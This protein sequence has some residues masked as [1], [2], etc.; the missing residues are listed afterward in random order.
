MESVILAQAIISIVSDFTFALY[1]ILILWNVKIKTKDKIGLC[2]LMGLG[3]IT[4][5]CCIVRTVLNNQALAADSSYGGITN[6]MWRLFEVQL[7]I[8]AACIPTLV[9]GYKW[10]R[11]QISSRS[12]TTSASKPTPFVK[13]PPHIHPSAVPETDITDLLKSG[14][15]PETQSTGFEFLMH[16]DGHSMDTDSWKDNSDDVEMNSGIKKTTT[17]D[18]GH[19]EHAPRPQRARGSSVTSQME[20]KPSIDLDLRPSF[21]ENRDLWRKMAGEGNH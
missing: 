2:A 10:T 6:W 19:I 3:L 5:A 11:R 18:V 1:P 16:K 20:P 12:H 15:A 4:G 8:I 9:P 21:E 13:E 17:V 7:G 14:T